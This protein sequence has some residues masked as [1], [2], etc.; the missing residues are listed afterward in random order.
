MKYGKYA[1]KRGY[2]RKRRAPLRKKGKTAL[3]IKITNVVNRTIH[4]NLE[5]K[6]VTEKNRIDFGSYV[7]DDT[8]HVTPIMPNPSSLVIPQGV[9]QG[10]RIGNTIKTRRLNLKYILYPNKQDDS[11]NPQPVPQEV[12]IWI[13]FLKGAKVISP[14]APSFDVF[15]QNGSNSSPPASN[16]WDSMLPVNKDLFTICKTFRHKLGNAIYTDYDNLKPR[17]Y[18][19]NNDF[20]LNCANS[21]DLTKFLNKTIKFNDDTTLCDTGLYM[22][23]EGVNADGSDSIVNQFPCAIQ[24]VLTYEYEDA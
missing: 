7:F 13:G 20:K 18:F 1:K 3:D 14:S 16:L 17:N 12:M 4:R 22:W 11:L 24:Y 2:L 21:V 6:I 19:S 23:M 9:K 8:L 5:N 15:Y 10:E